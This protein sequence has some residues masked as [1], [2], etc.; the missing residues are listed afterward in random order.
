MRIIFMNALSFNQSLRAGS[1]SHI[2]RG[3]NTSL[4]ISLE[5]RMTLP[6]RA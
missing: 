3:D 6:W 1:P 4:R 5:G 2:S